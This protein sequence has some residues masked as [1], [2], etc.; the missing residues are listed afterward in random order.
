MSE[1]RAG[2][3]QNF[4]IWV[5]LA[6]EKERNKKILLA[7]FPTVSPGHRDEFSPEEDEGDLGQALITKSAEKLDSPHRKLP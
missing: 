3:R 4:E 6:K 7:A 1:M 2:V 5:P